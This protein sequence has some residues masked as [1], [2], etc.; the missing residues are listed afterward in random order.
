M[1][2]AL[3]ASLLA[4]SLAMSESGGNLLR[5]GAFEDAEGGQPLHWSVYVAPADGAFGRYEPEGGKEKGGAVL[6]H[7]PL[8][9]PND[10]L[11]NWSQTIEGPFSGEQLHFRGALKTQE[12]TEAFHLIQ[13]WRRRPGGVLQTAS[14]RKDLPLSGTQDWRYVETTFQPPAGTDFIVVRC[15]LLG[16]G[17]AWF[18]ECYLGVA[19]PDTPAPAA[20]KVESVTATVASPPAATTEAPAPDAEL[21][22]LENQVKAMHESGNAMRSDVQRLRDS[23]DALRDQLEAV[24]RELEN[25][26]ETL[27]EA[28]PVLPQ[29]PVRP[30]MGDEARSPLPAPPLVPRNVE[31]EILP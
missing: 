16:V 14:T 15:V 1:T 6:L 23:N 27:R 4:A 29:Q 9:Y 25:V 13:A 3:I 21:R 18:D 31:W 19:P 28:A 26:R 22:L 30:E 12:A 24:R 17:S 2:L 11:N 8:P 7:T 20:Q 5:N 10:P